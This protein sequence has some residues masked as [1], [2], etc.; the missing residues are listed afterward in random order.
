L[1]FRPYRSRGA[2]HYSLLG[3][4][5]LFSSGRSIPV[6]RQDRVLRRSKAILSMSRSLPTL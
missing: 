4:N 3:I 6:L 1:H 5:P 2:C